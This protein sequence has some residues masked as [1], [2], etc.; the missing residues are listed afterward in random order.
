MRSNLK[1][2]VKID[3]K[4]EA[5][6]ASMRF[7]NCFDKPAFFRASIYD[8][9][10]KRLEEFVT[11]KIQR[12]IQPLSSQD[13]KKIMEKYTNWEYIIFGGLFFDGFVSG[14]LEI[15]NKEYSE[16]LWMTTTSSGYDTLINN[17]VAQKRLFLTLEKIVKMLDPGVI[18][19]N[20]SIDAISGWFE[21]HRDPYVFCT[22]NILENEYIDEIKQ[23]LQRDELIELIEKYSDGIIRGNEGIGVI[24][25]PGG[26]AESGS[27]GSYIYPRYF[28]RKE[29]R[30]RGLKLKPG[31]TERTITEALRTRPDIMRKLGI[32]DDAIYKRVEEAGEL[33]EKAVLEILPEDMLKNLGFKNND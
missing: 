22:D 13:I 32:I 16:F 28:I 21:Y 7:I 5:T 23:I 19:L 31:I 9:H 27:Y 30:A 26:R 10:H 3:K 8:Y 25:A 6:E 12:E 18:V 4:S 17:P 14:D 15:Y 20:T 33:T 24:R 1:L 2:R 11:K 29:I